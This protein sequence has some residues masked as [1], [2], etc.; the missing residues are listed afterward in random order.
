MLTKQDIAV[1]SDLLD[2][3][4]HP[5]KEDLQM[6]HKEFIGLN[7]KFNGLRQDMNEKI[8]GLREEMHAE[9]SRLDNKIDTKVDGLREEMHAEIQRLDNKIDGLRDEMH[10]GFAE[11]H[12]ILN[13]DIS[14][15]LKTIED[16][17]LKTFERYSEGAER[18]KKMEED[19]SVMKDVI[20]EHSVQLRKLCS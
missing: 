4:L 2:Q 16:C 7:N 18:Q 1:L 17:Y 9:I 13:T 8:D 20:Q 11:I 5:I 12:T 6:L 15:R 19:I 3:G 10:G 14:P